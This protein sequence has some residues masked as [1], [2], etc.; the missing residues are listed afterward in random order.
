MCEIGLGGMCARPFG[1]SVCLLIKHRRRAFSLARE[2]KQGA[3]Q[4]SVFG[5][6]GERGFA[7]SHHRPANR[8]ICKAKSAKSW[9]FMF[10]FA[11]G[12]D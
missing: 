1:T 7:A 9:T 2:W 8:V 11:G 3:E 6:L 4:L 12:F 10:F 5:H